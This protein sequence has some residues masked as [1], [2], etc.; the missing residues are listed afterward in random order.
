MILVASKNTTTRIAETIET[1]IGPI[2]MRIPAIILHTS[3]S[4]IIPPSPEVVRA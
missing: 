3:V 1:S 4:G 2:V